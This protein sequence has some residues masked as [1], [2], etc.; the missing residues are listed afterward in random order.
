MDIIDKV[1]ISYFRSLYRVSIEDPNDINVY[2]GSNDVGKSNILKALNLFFNSNT[3]WNE[4]LH[5]YKDINKERL[6]E[7]RETIKSKQV[8]WIAVTFRRPSNYDG[9]LPE[10]F[11]VRKTWQ[12][13][14]TVT[15]KSDL[16]TKSKN[17]LLPSS[18]KVARQYKSIFMDKVNYEYV[19]AIRSIDYYRYIL[20][21]LQTG[22]LRSE[23]DEPRFDSLI[24][25]V[26]E[27]I[28]DEVENLK[29]EFKNISGIRSSIDPPNDIESLFKSFGVQTVS[30]N[31]H[32]IPLL[33]RGDGIQSQYI[34]SVLRHISSLGNT[35]DIWGIEEPENSLEYSRVKEFCEKLGRYK[36]E[37]Q[38]MVTTHSPNITSMDK[39]FI[40]H[41]RVQKNRD[42][43]SDISEVEGEAEELKGDLGIEKMMSDI[44]EDYKKD[45]SN[46]ERIKSERNRLSKELARDILIVEGKTDKKILQTAYQKL[47]SRK[48]DFEIRK[49]NMYPESSENTFGG[50]EAVRRIIEGVHPDRNSKIIAIFDRDS[51]GIDKFER[52]NQFDSL[53]P[54]TEVKV[55]ISENAYAL[56]LPSPPNRP[57]FS[58]AE[59]LPIELLFEDDVLQ[60]RD[61]NGEGLDWKEEGLNLRTDSGKAIDTESI[62]DKDQIHESKYK[63]ISGNK[64]AFASNIVPNLPTE[65]F[66]NFIPLFLRIDAI[67]SENF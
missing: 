57:E 24:G 40:N 60:I 38:V 44:Y 18:L 53:S 11:R 19:P 2:T 28:N 8:I 3:E 48:P 30:S 1:E 5:F 7:I 9:S 6:Q 32:E 50:A 10:T 59:N 52:L 13:D 14:G 27:Y 49:S 51:K 42:M 64:K 33:Q 23:A 4:N 55:H 41:Y 58:E 39:E 36:N 54:E 45:M 63:R 37:A 66:K 62:L 20:S 29:D 35:F 43:V 15:E 16:E 56:L 65:K 17:G 61:D 31:G 46:L 22:I 34:V 26:R 21:K 12:K 67:Q 25:E 47:Y